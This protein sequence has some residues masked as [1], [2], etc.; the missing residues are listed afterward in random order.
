MTRKGVVKP[1]LVGPKSRMTIR[2]APV[3]FRACVTLLLA[4]VPSAAVAQLTPIDEKRVEVGVLKYWGLGSG[5]GART[6]VNHGRW[7]GS[8][9][10]LDGRFV[11][12]GFQGLLIGSAR[13]R[14]IGPRIVFGTVGLA[15]GRRLDRSV[16][17]VL[18]FGG[19]TATGLLDLRA[20]LQIFPGSSVY[21]VSNRRLVV[22][23]VLSLPW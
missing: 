11:D 16:M 3:V 4:L 8:E 18:G 14:S 2:H 6:T 12:D 23:F 9:L 10:S 15:L 21:G 13:I 1:R 7:I 17:P 22:A 5:V 19:Q 20:D